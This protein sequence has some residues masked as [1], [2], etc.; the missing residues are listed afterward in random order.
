[1]DLT[2]A[3]TEERLEFYISKSLKRL[4]EMA[5]QV[6]KHVELPIEAKKDKNLIFKNGGV[7]LHKNDIIKLGRVPYLVRES[8]IDNQK[9]TLLNLQSK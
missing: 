2:F 3:E 8:S 9:E 6:V 4:S 1:M 7:I 5:C